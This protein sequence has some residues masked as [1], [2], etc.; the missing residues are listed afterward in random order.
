MSVSESMPTSTSTPAPL[1][2]PQIQRRNIIQCLHPLSPPNTQTFPL[3]NRMGAPRWDV[4]LDCGLGSSAGG[5][6]KDEDSVVVL[7]TLAVAVSND[8][9]VI[10]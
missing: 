10:G 2:H 8:A 4:A 9:A 7:G 6:V 3:Y 1:N 5:G